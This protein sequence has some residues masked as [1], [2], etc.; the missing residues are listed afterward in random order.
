M[1]EKTTKEEEE[2]N[3]RIIELE[4]QLATMMD[5]ENLRDE[6]F[7]RKQRLM[8]DERKLV[9]MEK[10]IQEVGKLGFSEEPKPKEE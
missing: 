2:V 5:L 4:N 10:L 7:Y 3:P 9:L 6:S 8:M 1:T